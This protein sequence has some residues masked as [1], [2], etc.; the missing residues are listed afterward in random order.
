M[1]DVMQNYCNSFLSYLQIDLKQS[2]NTIISYKT[3][4][5]GYLTF[6]SKLKIKDANDIKIDHIRSF[7]KTLY[8]KKNNERTIAR[9]LSCIRKFHH[10]LLLEKIVKVDITEN[11]ATPKISKKLPSVLNE[12][13]IDKLLDIKLITPFD[14]RNKAML[15]LMYATGLRVSELVNLTIDDINL[16][17]DVL[18]CVGKGNKEKILPIGD[19]ALFYL[20]EY[21]NNH[22]NS[23]LKGYLTNKVFLNNHGK[24]ISR[25]A[26]FLLIKKIAKE[27][28]I[29]KEF[30]P[31]TLRHSFATHLLKHGA[32]LR[33][34]QELL[35]HSNISTTQIYTHI[36]DEKLKEDYI[37]YHPHSKK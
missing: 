36:G 18:R 21:L 11:I 17:M 23:L 3:D 34:I 32:D 12:E 5:N 27:K 13:E 26:F 10:F 16:E 2:D 15:E 9:K 6:L 20:K 33:S 31:H 35:G 14:H 4:I 1:N 22:R 8:D 37:Q 28:D 25:Q 7:L 24:G 30:S 29:K 19:I